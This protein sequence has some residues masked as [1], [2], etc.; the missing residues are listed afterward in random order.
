MIDLHCHI[1]PGV[2]DGAADTQESLAIARRLVDEGITAV[3][4]TPHLD[5]LQGNGVAGS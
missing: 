5:A 1:L 4:A 3:A 2:D